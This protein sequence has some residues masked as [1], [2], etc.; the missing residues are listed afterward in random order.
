MAFSK[1][2]YFIF[3]PS[4]S[5]QNIWGEICE[6]SS[7]SYT[8]STQCPFCTCAWPPIWHQRI[9]LAT[10]A[11]IA[12]FGIGAPGVT[13][14]IHDHTLINICEN[15]MATT[16]LVRSIS[17]NKTSKTRNCFFSL[18]IMLTWLWISLPTT[19]WFIFISLVFLSS[20]Y[21]HFDSI[22]LYI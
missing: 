19:V 7:V 16:L 22:L 4:R 12:A 6:I 5:T 9:P 1:P 21:F 14:S 10:A 17:F 11:F 2:R 8:K 13:T 18:Q 3:S 20:F 15:N